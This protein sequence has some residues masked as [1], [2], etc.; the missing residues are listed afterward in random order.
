[1]YPHRPPSQ[2]QSN[3]AYYPP[4]PPPASTQAQAPHQPNGTAYPPSSIPPPQQQPL[5]SISEYSRPEMAVH[6]AP[7]PPPPPPPPAAAAAAG[8]YPPPAYPPAPPAHYPYRPTH[9]PYRAPQQAYHPYPPQHQ[10]APRQRTA[11]ACRYCRRRKIRCSGFDQSEDGRCANCQ[12]F[13]QECVFTPVSAQAQAFVPAHAV[14]GRG[15][16]PPTQQLYGAY[17]QP[18]PPPQP[19]QHDPYAASRPP[20][21][22]L[23]SP[24]GG[25]YPPPPPHYP[26]AQPAGPPPPSGHYPP[27]E[28]SNGVNGTHKPRTNGEPHTPT[29]PPPNPATAPGAP[30]E[31]RYPDPN[32]VGAA[33]VS[34]ASSTS[35]QS[36][37]Q[38]YYPGQAPRR[39][40]PQTVSPYTQDG[41]SSASPNTQPQAYPPYP[42]DTT[43]KPPSN[44]TDGRTPPPVS[45]SA[46]TGQTVAAPTNTGGVRPGL[47][48]SSIVSGE[49]GAGG[50]SQ[51]DRDMLKR[52][53]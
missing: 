42:A 16:P 23:P 53:G 45:T 4:A 22:T 36:A 49:G 24:T 20:G 29:L 51:E 33:P 10:P 3:P 32:T 19:G 46:Q 6:H 34:P 48:I 40:P 50:R 2:D 44:L 39:T 37:P 5:P 11:I 12:R 43:L 25:H 47:S 28:V 27:H 14:Y 15:H 52:L 26:H 1:M 35:H 31:Y 9:D 7:P 8:A 13:S 18:L 21:Y 41:R 38:P 17:G 30:A